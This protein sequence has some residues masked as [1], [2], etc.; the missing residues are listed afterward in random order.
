MTTRITFIATILIAASAIVFSAETWATETVRPVLT[1][2]E[3]TLDQIEGEAPLA[4]RGNLELTFA[5]DGVFATG[6]GCNSFKGTAEINGSEILFP[7]QLAGTMMAC[8]DGLA[9]QEEQVLAL[10]A[11]V[12]SFEIDAT[13]LVLLDEDG[14]ELLRYRRDAE[15]D[16]TLVETGG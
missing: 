16:E 10:L 5:Q 15:P 1:D 7:D 4:G 12:V 14:T 2:T 13:V 3:W 11:Q 8:P 9:E 6:A